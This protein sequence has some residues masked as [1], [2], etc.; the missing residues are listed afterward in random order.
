MYVGANCV[1]ERRW[2]CTFSSAKP[3]FLNAKRAL[4]ECSV[5]LITR[6]AFNASYKNQDNFI[7]KSQTQRFSF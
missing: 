7:N 4:N 2:F 3:F 1:S 5:F 6:S